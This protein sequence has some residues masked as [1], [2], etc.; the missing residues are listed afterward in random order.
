MILAVDIGY[1][2]LKLIYGSTLSDLSAMILPSIAAPSRRVARAVGGGAAE[3][4]DIKVWVD[5]REY[6]AC[7]DPA[8][9]RVERVLHE[10]YA[11]EDTYRALYRAALLLAGK[12]E[13]ECVVTGLPVSQ[14]RD[15][16]RVARI[17]ELMG[18]RVEVTAGRLV[19]VKQVTVLPQPAGS[20][21]ELVAEW[22]GPKEMLRGNIV[23]I[24]PG[25]FSVDW[26]QLSGGRVQWEASGTS[27]HATS[28]ILEGAAE[29]LKA[30]H[31][32]WVDSDTMEH[33]LRQGR[34]QIAAFGRMLDIRSALQEAAADPVREALRAVRASVRQIRAEPGIV[35]L[36]GGGCEYYR[37]RVSEHFPGWRV[38]SGKV[39][40][41]SNVRGFWLY[42]SRA[43]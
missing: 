24:D 27:L 14:A 6:V 34:A 41:M 39:P 16:E 13:F 19:N 36:A 8:Y 2:S 21:F 32:G 28:R 3:S 42:Q 43:K 25:Y 9:T 18:G 1:S 4:P 29:L 37:E 7:C 26:I 10:D 31:G 38:W 12:E 20:Y 22:D 40:V 30:R 35:V 11:E 33:A 17:Q 5:G 15:P 23:V